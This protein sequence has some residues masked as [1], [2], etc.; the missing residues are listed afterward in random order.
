MY[1]YIFIDMYLHFSTQYDFIFTVEKM[2]VVKDIC[3]I[4]LLETVLVNN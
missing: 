4:L 2:G 3:L 1:T